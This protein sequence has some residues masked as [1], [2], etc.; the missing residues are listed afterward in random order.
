MKTYQ[1]INQEIQQIVQQE[2]AKMYNE[3]TASEI[4]KR[5]KEHELK[6]DMDEIDDIDIIL[7]YMESDH[8]LQSLSVM[9]LIT[10]LFRQYN[11][12]E[13]NA[14]SSHLVTEALEEDPSNRMLWLFWVLVQISLF[15]E[16]EFF[17]TDLAKFLSEIFQR[18]PYL[19]DLEEFFDATFSYA[20]FMTHERLTSQT[21]IY[22]PVFES[23]MKKYPAKAI[24]RQYVGLMYYHLERYEESLVIFD[25]LKVSLAKKFELRERIYIDDGHFDYLFIIEMLARNYDILGKQD[26][27]EELVELV[28]N[29]L[30]VVYYL[31][32]KEEEDAGSYA[33]SFFLRMRLNV[34]KNKIQKVFEDWDRIKEQVFYVEDYEAAY[35]DVFK[36]LN[37]KAKRPE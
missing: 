20:L 32:G 27:V 5:V 21:E 7:D 31:G 34:K 36:I 35:P 12:D 11:E 16:E 28:I 14:E 18:C 1:F 29:N 19:V 8:E 10:K 13:F 30:P 6:D 22:L 3:K 23:A 24:I 4:L 2:A 15:E 33:D 25:Q 26:H 9:A 37:D 17:D